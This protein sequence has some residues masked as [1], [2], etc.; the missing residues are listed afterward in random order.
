MH[1]AEL[2]DMRLRIAELRKEEVRRSS[3]IKPGLK[4]TFSSSLSVWIHTSLTFS[5]IHLHNV[6]TD[7]EVNIGATILVAKQTQSHGYMERTS[8]VKYLDYSYECP[9]AV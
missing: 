8:T 9:T 7:P 6:P 4:P 3:K 2:T 5:F 1:A